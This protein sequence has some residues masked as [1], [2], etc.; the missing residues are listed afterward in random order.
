MGG[1]KTIPTPFFFLLRNMQVREVPLL[2]NCFLCMSWRYFNLLTLIITI[3]FKRCYCYQ[4]K[5]EGG[6]G[7]GRGVMFPLNWGRSVRV[8]SA[9]SFYSVVPFT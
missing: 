9:H 3:V 4:E 7:G 2:C 1:V 6:G 5:M 8:F